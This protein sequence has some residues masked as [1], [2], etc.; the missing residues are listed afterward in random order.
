MGCFNVFGR[1]FRLVIMSKVIRTLK[2]YEATKCF[3]ILL[4][5][6]LVVFI[7]PILEFFDVA[8][9]NTHPDLGLYATLTGVGL[10]VSAKILNNKLKRRKSLKLYDDH[11]VF[12]YTDG[13]EETIEFSDIEECYYNRKKKKLSLYLT[14]QTEYEVS[15]YSTVRFEY[16]ARAI[17][18]FNPSL[19]SDEIFDEIY[20]STLLL[21]YKK[22]RKGLELFLYIGNLFFVGGFGVFMYIV[23]YFILEFEVKNTIS[24]KKIQLKTFTDSLDESFLLVVLL[25]VPFLILLSGKVLKNFRK[26]KKLDLR[27]SLRFKTKYLV[28]GTFCLYFIAGIMASFQIIQMKKDIAKGILKTNAKSVLT[29][30][31]KKVKIDLRYNCISCLDSKYKIKPG[32]EIA[33]RQ[34][35]K[36]ITIVKVVGVPRV[37][38]RNNRTYYVYHSDNISDIEPIYKKEVHSSPLSKGMVFY[39]N[40]K[41][42]YKIKHEDFNK[43]KVQKGRRLVSNY[44]VYQQHLEHYREMFNKNLISNYN[45]NRNTFYKK[46]S[47]KNGKTFYKLTKRKPSSKPLD[48]IKDLERILHK[49]DIKTEREE[50]AKIEAKKHVLMTSKFTIQGIKD[51]NGKALNKKNL[52]Y[53]DI[54]KG[55]KFTFRGVTTVPLKDFY[56]SKYSKIIATTKENNKEFITVK[57]NLTGV[58]ASSKTVLYKAASEWFSSAD[59]KYILGKVIPAKPNS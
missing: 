58:K 3:K 37:V 1:L 23:T 34:K 48:N 42:F 28:G 25:T 35:N 56:K 17:N 26:F 20:E 24:L 55:D 15:I 7:I 36:P 2:Y 29:K 41:N 30:K 5:C 9:F 6:S 50:Y 49:R 40:K 14:D 59:E 13:E 52:Y 32:D 39:D 16:I 57:Y 47:I 33:L 38:K 21:V 4:F 44:E 22:H 18:D 12:V 46:V 45:K 31:V 27:E 11:I 10:L 19:I 54:P 8:P 53:L 51:I 43:V